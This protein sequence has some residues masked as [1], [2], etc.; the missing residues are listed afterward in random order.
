MNFKLEE[1][2]INQRA[3]ER[4]TVADK[5]LIKG[6]TKEQFDKYTPDDCVQPLISRLKNTG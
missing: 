4:K 1:N 6:T 5:S 2:K 3:R